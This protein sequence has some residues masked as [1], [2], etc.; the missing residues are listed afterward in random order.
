MQ[1]IFLFEKE[2]LGPKGKVKGRFV[3]TGIVPKF[4]DKLKEAGIPMPTGL[5][6]YAVEV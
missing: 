5:L 3:S 2:G 4:G 6:D 1:D